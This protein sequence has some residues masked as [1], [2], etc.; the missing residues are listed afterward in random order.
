ME[1]RILIPL[2]LLCIALVL[3]A[4]CASEPAW[5]PTPATTKDPRSV[6]V[7]MYSSG[8]TLYAD[9]KNIGGERSYKLQIDLYSGSVK[10]DTRY[11]TTPV[12]G[13]GETGRVK[14]YMPSD[15]TTYKLTAVAA[16][17]GGDYYRTYY[18]VT[19]A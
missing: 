12:L 2:F 5:T 16:N 14:I 7:K 18:D 11:P 1:K 13:Y 17:V 15:T 10:T 4:G 8:D 3:V 9:V 19:Y 6:I